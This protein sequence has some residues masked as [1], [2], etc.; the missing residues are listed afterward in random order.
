MTVNS[1]WILL[2][3]IYFLRNLGFVMIFLFSRFSEFTT[4][5]DYQFESVEQEALYSLDVYKEGKTM[6]FEVYDCSQSLNPLFAS[7]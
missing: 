2:A 3:T 7:F 4:Q 1:C 6:S 5:Q